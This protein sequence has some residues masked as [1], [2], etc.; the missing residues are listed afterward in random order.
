MK[1]PNCS[2]LWTMQ[3]YSTRGWVHR[4]GQGWIFAELTPDERAEFKSYQCGAITIPRMKVRL[5]Y[6]HPIFSSYAYLDD[7]ANW[8]ARCIM[9]QAHPLLLSK[10]HLHQI[11][12]AEHKS[13]SWP[14]LEIGDYETWLWADEVKMCRELGC[15]MT[16]RCGYGWRAW[17]V[18]PEWKPPLPPVQYKERV[19][20]YALVDELAREAYIGHSGN[21]RRRLAQHLRGTENPDKVA[22]IQ[23]LRAQGREPE[24]RTLE[25][26]AGKEAGGRERY[27]TSYYKS[28]GYK[29]INQDF[30]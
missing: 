9:R 13:L 4:E 18:P 7:Y 27:W 14:P 19:F 30:R 28:Q 1:T 22:L 24:L 10:F 26:V 5:P 12:T 20:I 15:E 29:I 16:I 3:E 23:S 21:L 11:T 17:D 6:G 25:E 2:V 8:F